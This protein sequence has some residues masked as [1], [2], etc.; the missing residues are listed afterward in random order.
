MPSKYQ[1]MNMNV[2]NYNLRFHPVR[3]YTH[4][5]IEELIYVPVPASCY[6]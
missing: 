2:L 5:Q 3:G 6:P 1:V 4:K